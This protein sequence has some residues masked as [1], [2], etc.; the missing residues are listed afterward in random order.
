MKMNTI[1]AIILLV[2]LSAG[3]GLT[4]YYGTQGVHD[5]E[6]GM[7]IAITNYTAPAPCLFGYCGTIPQAQLRIQLQGQIAIA[8]S[9][10]QGYWHLNDTVVIERTAYLFK[11]PEV[12]MHDRNDPS[13][14]IGQC[15]ST[16][17]SFE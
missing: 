1:M 6:K 7:I 14:V 17:V 16:A 3:A 2:S 10:C 15:G 13:G 5:F 8:I 12:M 11:S 9:N 4:A